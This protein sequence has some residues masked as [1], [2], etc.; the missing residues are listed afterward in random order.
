MGLTGF[1]AHRVC[2]VRIVIARMIGEG[3]F[4][5]AGKDNIFGCCGLKGCTINQSHA[6]YVCL[7][8]EKWKLVCVVFGKCLFGSTF[9]RR[10]EILTSPCPTPI[11]P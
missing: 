9:L 4:V 1:R 2:W 7:L 6:Q 3:L 11:Q 10:S 5:K 8:G